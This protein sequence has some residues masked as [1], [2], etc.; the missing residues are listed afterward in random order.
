MK[1]DEISTA[2]AATGRLALRSREHVQ[3][4]VGAE[5]VL[6]KAANETFEHARSL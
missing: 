5:H 4:A 2:R 1:A 6:L 3:A